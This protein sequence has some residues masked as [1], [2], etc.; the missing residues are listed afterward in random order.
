MSKKIR[1]DGNTKTGKEEWLTPPWVIEA[2]G[3][4][5]LDPC[6]PIVRPWNTAAKHYT[7]EDN[8]LI[9]PWNGKVWINPPYDDCLTW[10]NLAAEHGNAIGTCFVRTE[11]KWFKEAIWQKATAILWK[12]GRL[13]FYNVD[14][15]P[16][17]TGSGIGS[18]FMAYGRQNAARLLKVSE[19]IIPGHFQM[20]R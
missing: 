7:I 12:Y 13:N 8:G 11:T 15:T 14:G 3:P 9:Q 18:I 4:F 2:F 6:A 20:L 19:T 10:F 5:D 17:K 16:G 1:H